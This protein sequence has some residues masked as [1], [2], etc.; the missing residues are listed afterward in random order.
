[1]VAAPFWDAECH[2][3]SA[4]HVSATQRFR[5]LLGIATQGPASVRGCLRSPMGVL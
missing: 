1:V 2:S 4:F 3:P 5:G